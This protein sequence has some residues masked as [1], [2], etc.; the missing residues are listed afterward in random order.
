M[1]HPSLDQA[2][3]GEGR[4][5]TRKSRLTAHSTCDF[6][7][8]KKGTVFPTN[9]LHGSEVALWRRNHTRQSHDSFRDDCKEAQRI[10]CYQDIRTRTSYD[11]VGP[12]LEELVL[13]FLS[14]SL[15]ILFLGLVDSLE[16]LAK[17][18]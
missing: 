15:H 6:I 3:N 13:Q 4:L 7:Q 18:R 1:L 5:P 16:A 8:D 2:I 17:G 10:V 12:E 14:E 11:C 9:G